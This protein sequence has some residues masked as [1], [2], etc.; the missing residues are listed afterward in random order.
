MEGSMAMEGMESEVG[1]QGAQDVEGA[2]KHALEMVGGGDMVLKSKQLEALDAL[3]RGLD[4]FLLLPTG[5]GKSISFEC[6]PFLYDYKLSPTDPS[7]KCTVLV[8]S[9]LISL[10]VNQVKSLRRRKVACCILS[11]NPGIEKDIQ[12]VSLSPGEYSLV[13]TA[14][15]AIIEN[16]KWQECLLELSAHGS[17][18]A[19][20][21]DEAHCVSRW[22]RFFRPSYGRLGEIRALVPSGTPWLACTATATHVVR[23]DVCRILDTSGCNVILL[24]KSPDR[25][26][27]YYEVHERRDIKSDFEP[28]VKELLSN[29]KK[30]NR[31]IVYC[32][33]MNMC[34]DIYIH[35]LTTLGKQS[36]YPDGAEQISD[37]R[38]FGMFHSDTPTHNKEVILKSMGKEDGVARFVFATVALGMGVNFKGLNRT[39]H[40]AAPT[41]VEGIRSCRK[42]RK[43]CQIHHILEASRCTP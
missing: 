37:N 9:P 27:I 17:I 42:V 11:G 26:N 41:S 21:V 10:M 35:F 2:I 7:K 18:V 34:S 40:Y 28:L 29:S 5:Y 39:I 33:S 32:R 30:A 12:A 23:E 25:P 16:P 19:V 4:V 6:L 31:V 15:E 36:Y 14:P 13:F 22:S 43:F 24:C 8:V 20:C 3:Y 38:L 1:C